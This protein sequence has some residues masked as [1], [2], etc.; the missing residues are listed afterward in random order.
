M[1]CLPLCCAALAFTFALTPGCKKQ[2][3]KGPTGDPNEVVASVDGVKYLRKEMDEITER[4]LK[5]QNVPEEQMEEMRDRI[6]RQ[7]IVNFVQ[8]AVLLNEV[9][10]EGITLTEEDRQK[11]IARLE[12][13]VKERGVADS[14]EAY[15]KAHPL[16]E[17]IARKEFADNMLFEKL[18]Q[19]KLVDPVEVEDAEVD[20]LFDSIKAQNA[21]AEEANKN[22]EGKEAKLAKIQDIKK[23]LADGANFAELAKEHSA[24]QSKERGGDL[25]AF[26]RGMMVKEF[27]D[28]AFTQE[29]GKVGEIVETKFGY[30]LILVTERNAATEATD[31]TP[32]TPETATASHILLAFDR[33]QR[34]Q[35]IP[36]A[37]DVRNYIKQQKA[38]PLV[39]DYVQ[40]LRDKAKIESIIPIE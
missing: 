15:F 36:S 16:G 11:G 39:Q 2:E 30:H 14:S 1:K 37:D 6:E 12:E 40:G 28:A 25:G 4:V 35:P 34:I 17:E 27:E 31:D 5:V 8:K 33:E 3:G 9:K 7:L 24:C 13:Q 20:A 38:Q 29:I 21:A 22:L 32:A 23:K 19:V 18:L 10:K 26:Q